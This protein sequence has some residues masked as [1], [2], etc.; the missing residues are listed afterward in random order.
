MLQASYIAARRLTGR[1]EVVQVIH[2]NECVVSRVQ[3]VREVV[4][5]DIDEYEE[6]CEC[7]EVKTV[8]QREIR[9]YTQ[10]GETFHLWLHADKREKLELQRPN[11]NP[12]WL[13]PKVYKGKSMTDLGEDYE[14]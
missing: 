13:T 1:K 12:G 10:K 7:C 6:G 4:V 3:E 2:K 11:Y 5:D 8:F 9:V 14:E